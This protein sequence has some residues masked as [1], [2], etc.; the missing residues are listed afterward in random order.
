MSSCLVGACRLS[1]QSYISVAGNQERKT[2]MSQN[3]NRKGLALGAIFALVVSAFTTAPAALAAD[4]DQLKFTPDAGTTYTSLVTEDFKMAVSLKPA[5]VSTGYGALKYSIK[6][7]AGNLDVQVTTSAT[8]TIGDLA[9]SSASNSILLAT[10]TGTLTVSPLATSS[11]NQNGIVLR[12]STASG[13]TN[14]TSESAKTTV[15]VTAWIDSSPANNKIDADEYFVTQTVDFVPFSSLT[16]AVT[17]TDPVVGDTRITAS[18]TVAGINLEQANGNFFFA[19]SSSQL[20]SAASFSS[21]I[22][23]TAVLSASRAVTA[24]ALNASVSAQLRYI[25]SGNP[26]DIYG[27]VAVTAVSTKGATARGIE[28][29]TVSPLVGDNVNASND[30]RVNSTFTV[31]AGVSTGSASVS[32]VVVTFN[33]TSSAAVLSATK[34]LSINGVA[35]TESKTTFTVTATSGADGFASITVGTSGYANTDTVTVTA[36]ARN[37]SDDQAFDLDSPAYTVENEYDHYSTT[38]GTAVNIKYSVADQWDVKSNRTDYR[39]EIIRGGSGFNY[40]ET[41]SYVAVVNGAASFAFTP[42]PATKTG[43]ATV[44]ANLQKYDPDNNIWSAN[45]T[46]D[47]NI[48]VNV[49]ATAD[50]F[51]VSPAASYSASISYLATSISWSSIADVKVKNPGASVTI[52]SQGLIFREAAGKASV[53]NSLTMRSDANGSISFQVASVKA[54]TFTISLTVGSSTTTSQ[55]VVDPAAHDSGKTITFDTTAIAAGATKVITGTVVDANGNPVHTSGSSVVE[56]TYT[57]ASGT[58]GI[59]IGSLPTET[60]ADGKFSFTVFTGVSDK[61]FATLTAK[62]YKSGVASTATKDIVSTTQNIGVGQPAAAAASKI[63]VGSFTGKVVVYAKGYT[64]K[65]VSYRIAGKWGKMVVTK[66]LQSATRLVGSGKAIKVDVY[67]DGSLVK[68]E[69]ITTK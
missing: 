45:G 52:A 26:S 24:L 2:S 32:G 43:S 61:G 62:Y 68:S 16:A 4:G 10:E 28:N 27:G 42:S 56:V 47:S 20:A 19:F 41:T 44:E 59:V 58:A 1:D 34:T 49:S 37:L 5:F 17:L 23:P 40:A 9:S 14:V 7:T 67:V 12:P 53:S 57:I 15:V 36:T 13:V 51:S 3:T 8:A 33:V 30:A 18:A 50:S 48:S 6:R 25:A 60:D 31:R 66:D 38:P 21:N 63:T 55:L 22:A 65:T 46:D 69:T 29:L 39:L 11:T 35:Y 54:G 64:G